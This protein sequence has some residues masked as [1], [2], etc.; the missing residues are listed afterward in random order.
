VA[1]RDAV[2]TP[3]HAGF[4]RSAGRCQPPAYV[5]AAAGAGP[6]GAGGAVH[7]RAG[8]AG[9]W[10]A[11]PDRRPVR[12]GSVR[13]GR[14]CTGRRLARGRR[15]GVW[16]SW[17][18]DR[19]SRSAA[20]VEPGEVGRCCGRRRIGRSRWSMGRQRV[21]PC[22]VCLRRASPRR[23]QCGRSG[24]PA[25]GLHDANRLGAGCLPHAAARSRRAAAGPTGPARPRRRPDEAWNE[26]ERTIATRIGPLFRLS[27]MTG[28]RT[29]RTGRQFVAGHAGHLPVRGR[30]DGRSASPT[31][32]PSPPL[33]GWPSWWHEQHG[34]HLR[35]QEVYAS[36]M[37]AGTVCHVVPAET[38]HRRNSW[39]A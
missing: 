24:G 34:A 25:C 28:S 19:R 14:G 1:G 10:A 2:R 5:L 15:T 18:V 22:G 13:P 9:Y 20:I 30:F 12:A 33:P 3:S 16:S 4:R 17:R 36:V 35:E 38:L 29:L 26:L 21:T 6:G 32:S 39:A 8:L 7:R 11:G 31:S 23:G 37:D 27:D